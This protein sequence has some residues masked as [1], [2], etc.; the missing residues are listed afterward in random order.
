MVKAIRML[1]GIMLLAGFLGG[2]QATT[3]KTAGQ[4][5][6][7]SMVTSKVKGELA[8]HQLSSLGR[9]GVD[10]VNGE[11]NLTGVVRSPE[12]KQ[13]AARVARQVEGVKR[14]NNNLRVQGQ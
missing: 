5:V 8:N 10:T 1:L 11:V 4:H 13:E 7:D 3:G 2:C 6:D 9:V 12:E 14:V